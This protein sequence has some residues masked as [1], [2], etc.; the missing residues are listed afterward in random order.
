MA[1]AAARITTEILAADAQSAPAFAPPRKG[2]PK[3]E[4][5]LSPFEE[6]I[7]R[8]PHVKTLDPPGAGRDF[9]CI[10]K[11]IKAPPPEPGRI[12]GH[13]QVLDSWELDCSLGATLG[14]NFL[15][16]LRRYPDEA[17]D[18]IANT[19]FGIAKVGR[20]SGVEL[21]FINTIAELARLGSSLP[22]AALHVIEA[23]VRQEDGRTGIYRSE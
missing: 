13:D 6:A 2:R 18:L 17:R 22:P 21:G 20:A 9:W 16:V 12:A 1:Q 10:G 15:D 3:P 4:P 23:R 7:W 8:L 5:E 11:T 14:R 19:L